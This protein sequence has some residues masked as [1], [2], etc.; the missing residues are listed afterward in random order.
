VILVVVAA[1]VVVTA[2]V[3]RRDAA[4]TAVAANATPGQPVVAPPV[5]PPGSACA[6]CTA[7]NCIPTTD[8]CDRVTDPT[9]RKLCQDVYACFTNADYKCVSQ[10]DPLKCWCGKQP[11]TCV[12]ANEPP[13]QADGPCLEKVF[14]AAKTRDAATVRSRFVDPSLPIGR[15]VRLSLCRGSFCTAECGVP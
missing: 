1:G 8:G 6:V 7:Q 15:A 3:T 4:S 9:D 13:K 5:A 11:T 14:A 10:G 12:T 2:L